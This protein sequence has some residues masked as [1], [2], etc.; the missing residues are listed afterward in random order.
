VSRI[1]LTA[2]AAASLL[3]MGGGGSAHASF[4]G[5]PGLVAF[6]R[7][8]SNSIWLMEADGRNQR[9]LTA[10]R[11]RQS[12]PAWSPN[13]RWLLY[14]ADGLWI[15]RPDGS[16]RRRVAK[17]ALEGAWSPDGGRIVLVSKETQRRC[18]DLYSMRLSGTQ[19]RQITS[20]GACE[21]EPS[22]SPDGNWITFSAVTDYATHIVVT[23]SNGSRDGRRVIGSGVSPDWSPDG[24][25]VAFASG[26]T[27]VIV[28]PDGRELRRLE[29]GGPGL[30]SISAV[31]WSPAG[32]AFVFAQTEAPGGSGRGAREIFR[33]RT[34]GT[35]RRR[36]TV[37]SIDNDDDPAWQSR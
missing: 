24:K 29:L 16:G 15:I 13:G 14:R 19:V 7:D 26:T 2:A 27:I 34:D 8:I 9:R 18:T 1:W 6:T 11:E 37:T 12:K 32:D 20:T 3:A 35:D 21:Y 28:A 30:G 22:Y 23:R 25:A 4:P 36:L 17:Y 10:S 33:V 5:T 31:S